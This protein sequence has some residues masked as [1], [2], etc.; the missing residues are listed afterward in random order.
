MINPFAWRKQSHGE[1]VPSQVLGACL[2]ATFIGCHGSSF[3]ILQRILQ[4]NF[5]RPELLFLS[6]TAL[7]AF[8]GVYKPLPFTMTSKYSEGEWYEVVVH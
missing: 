5:S 3:R 6:S 1:V 4:L 2:R 8:V 7:P